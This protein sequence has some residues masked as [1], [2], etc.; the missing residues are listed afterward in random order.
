MNEDF[1]REIFEP[2]SDAFVEWFP[3]L[4][5]SWEPYARHLFDHQFDI[6]SIR[7][8]VSDNRDFHQWLLG[9]NLVRADLPPSSVDDFIRDMR[10]R[11]RKRNKHP[12]DRRAVLDVRGAIES[13]LAFA[14]HEQSRPSRTPPTSG[15]HP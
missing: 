8:A 12:M 1:L 6:D 9:Q 3:H 11:F 5:R 7:K 10:A 13:F 14:A 2:P 4:A 15:T